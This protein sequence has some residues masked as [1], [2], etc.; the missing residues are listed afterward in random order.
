MDDEPNPV[1]DIL[2]AQL[3]SFDEENIAKSLASGDS[4]QIIE[5]ITSECITKIES[6]QGDVDENI[7]T[8][9]TSLLH[10]LLTISLIP[11][12][13]KIEYNDCQLD[14]I[15]PDLRTLRTS[16]KDCLVITISITGNREKINQQITK[17]QKIQPNKEN[18]WIVLNKPIDLEYKIF[19]VNIGNFSTILEEISKF[20]KS[21]K[22]T[23]FRIFKTN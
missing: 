12:Q 23:Q 2:Y 7:G 4:S 16:P 10:Y 5:K 3:K 9:A 6:L 8:F 17:I 21:K 14:I 1:K 13:R 11:S 22:Q 15:I 20:L 18:I 19:S